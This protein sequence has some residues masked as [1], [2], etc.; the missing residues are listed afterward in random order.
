L[1]VDVDLLGGNG[2][3]DIGSSNFT[4]KLRLDLPKCWCVT[5]RG[6]VHEVRPQTEEKKFL[7]STTV[8]FVSR[9]RRS[10]ELVGKKD[11]K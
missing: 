6:R 3:S 7:K 10:E 1:L 9:L 2:V 8:F 5:D 4:R 11:V